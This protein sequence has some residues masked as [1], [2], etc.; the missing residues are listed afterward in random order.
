M[1]SSKKSGRSAGNPAKQPKSAVDEMP[2]AAKEM[3]LAATDMIG[4]TGAESFELR[5][6]E[7]RNPVVWM[8]I[9]RWNDTYEVGASISPIKATIRLLET[10]VDGGTCTTCGKPTG[11][12]EDL[13]AMPLG[14]HVCWYQYDPE[15]KAF[16][17]GCE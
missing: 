4:R 9:G 7:K 11:I 12:T 2:P 1:T 6:S 8:A 17:R 13:E 15:L 3:L 14:S 10:V 5:Y 16:R